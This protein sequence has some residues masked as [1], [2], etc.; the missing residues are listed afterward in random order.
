MEFLVGSVVVQC[1]VLLFH[2]FFDPEQGT[3]CAWISFRFSGFLLPLR[4]MKVSG[5]TMLSFL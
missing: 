1:L 2:N 3:V 5:L 4:N